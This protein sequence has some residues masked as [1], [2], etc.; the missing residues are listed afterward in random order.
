MD[1]QR[2]AEWGYDFLKYDWCSYGNMAKDT[3]SPSCKSLTASWG[4]SC[5]DKIATWC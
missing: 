4:E 1:A 5:A 3:A 2:F